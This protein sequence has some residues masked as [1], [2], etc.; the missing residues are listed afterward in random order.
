MGHAPGECGCRRLFQA[1]LVATASSTPSN[2]STL[3]L[4]QV[5]FQASMVVD[6][7]CGMLDQG[8]RWRPLHREAARERSSAPR[9]MVLER[10]KRRPLRNMRRV[11]WCSSD[12]R[13]PA[14]RGGAATKGG[15]WCGD[16]RGTWGQCRHKQAPCADGEKEK[17]KAH[18]SLVP[19]SAHAE[20]LP[21]S[22]RRHETDKPRPAENG[23]KDALE[24]DNH[25][26]FYESDN[27][28][29]AETALTRQRHQRAPQLGP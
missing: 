18:S 1:S 16:A 13:D 6:G 20:P 17:K 21:T 14:E 24:N 11:G 8:G 9:R 25:S 7:R 15:A 5:K 3:Q 26:T 28:R 27:A 29:P 4:P 22:S 10:R 2:F 19:C 23:L 12:P